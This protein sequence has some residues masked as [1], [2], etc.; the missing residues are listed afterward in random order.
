MGYYVSNNMTTKYII[1]TDKQP[2]IPEGL[3]IEK[4]IKG[5]KFEWNPAHVELYLSENQKNGNYITGNQLLKELKGKPV[6]NA[7]VL[8]Y[9]L[10]HPELIPEDWKGKY[11]FF[12][13]TLYRSS[14][15]NL[16]VRCLRWG[17]SRWNWNDDWLGLDWLDNRPAAVR[18]SSLNLSI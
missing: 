2:F 8:D 7:N 1:D 4:H 17:G 5:G 6:L 15:G 3:R 16:F 14:G 12:W 13:G 11:V 10:A 18:A 9:L